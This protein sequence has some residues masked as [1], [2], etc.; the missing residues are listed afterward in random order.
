MTQAH[1]ASAQCATATVTSFASVRLG[2]AAAGRAFRVS[3]GTGQ[4][5]QRQ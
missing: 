1:S 2:D 4:T 3:I 5:A